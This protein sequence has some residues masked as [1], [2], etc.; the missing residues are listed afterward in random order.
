MDRKAIFV[1]RVAAVF[2]L[3]FVLA[4]PGTAFAEGTGDYGQRLAAAREK[5]DRVAE[6]KLKGDP[7]WEKD[8]K[9]VYAELLA[10]IKENRQSAEAYYLTARC[11]YYDGSPRKAIKAAKNAIRIDPSYVDGLVFIGDM[12]VE[13]MKN[14]IKNE[15]SSNIEGAI[16]SDS[17]DATKAYETALKVVGLAK[18]TEGTIYLKLGDLNNLYDSP[19]RKKAAREFWQKASESV[20]ESAA[21][22]AA[23]ERLKKN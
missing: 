2:F 12:H 11:Y 3:M 21:A 19:Q 9:A 18:E 10:L 1:V 5:V 23:S 14:I 7:S 16:H 8:L 15:F 17:K 6:Y 22:K 20:P 13:I 4:Y